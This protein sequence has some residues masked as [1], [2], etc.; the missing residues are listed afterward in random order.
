MTVVEL[1]A[2]FDRAFA[3][4]EAAMA[5]GEQ[6]AIMTYDGEVN[7]IMR[8]I[9]AADPSN[10]EEKKVLGTFLLDRILNLVEATPLTADM[11]E[12]I[13]KTCL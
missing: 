1:I 12:K 8:S 6:H 4:L 9:L 2:S 11:R 13:V 10:D 5:S 3:R 7:E